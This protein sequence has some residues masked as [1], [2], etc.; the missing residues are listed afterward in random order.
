MIA[1]T[2]TKRK[3]PRFLTQTPAKLKNM[4]G[5][6]WYPV[7]IVNLSKSGACVTGIFSRKV[8]TLIELMV[9]SPERTHLVVAQIMW[10]DSEKVGLKFIPL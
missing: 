7:T 4:S 2:Q 6:S 5:T 3:D 8:G 1:A 9:P 10:C